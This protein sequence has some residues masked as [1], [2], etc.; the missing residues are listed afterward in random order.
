MFHSIHYSCDV[1]G[2]LR[3][4]KFWLAL[5]LNQG[6]RSIFSN[7]PVLCGYSADITVNYLWLIKIKDERQFGF[8]RWK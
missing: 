8:I 1:I 2:Q 6:F 5:Y 4:Q 3:H 7:I